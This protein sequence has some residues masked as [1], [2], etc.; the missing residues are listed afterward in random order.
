MAS[1]FPTRVCRARSIARSN[2]FL[3]ASGFRLSPPCPTRQATRSPMRAGSASA[4]WANRVRP[5]ISCAGGRC[6]TGSTAPT[7][8]R[9]PPRQKCLLHG[10]PSACRAGKHVVEDWFPVQGHTLN[11]HFRFVALLAAALL[12][13]D[14]HGE[15]WALDHARSDWG[16]FTLGVASGIVAHEL[17]H[18]VVATSKGYK[19]DHDGLSIIYPGATFTDAEQLQIASAG[20]QT[21]WLLTELGLPDRNGKEREEQQR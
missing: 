12:S 2:A 14:A 4:N 13:T 6:S 21:Q 9:V 10:L 19:V 20:F 7:A 11:G 5:G 16:K 15:G 3:P 8:C 1:T 18:Y 17:G